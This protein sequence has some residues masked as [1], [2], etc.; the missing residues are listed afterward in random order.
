MSLLGC[1][2]EAEKLSKAP[3]DGGDRLGD[4]VCFLRSCPSLPPRG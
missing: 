3:V 4:R 1:R 2:E